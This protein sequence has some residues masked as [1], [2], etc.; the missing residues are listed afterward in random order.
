MWI[1]LCSI[2][3]HSIFQDLISYEVT[4]VEPRLRVNECVVGSGGLC[5]STE[6]NRRFES[7][8]KS[9]IGKRYVYNYKQICA[10]MITYRNYCSSF[11]GMT[12]IARSNTMRYF[13]EY[14]KPKFC[15][16]DP[17]EEEDDDFDIET[18]HCPVPGLQDCS[19]KGIYGGHLLLSVDDMK[20][21]F[22]PTFSEIT[23]LVQDQV[24]NAERTANKGV[25]V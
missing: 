22:D 4:A 1:P 13:D 6:L 15:P 24:S 9:K 25:T 23:S 16:P 11:D 20:G 10:S 14:L 2:S 3:K 21:I 8:V 17:N 19:L 5:G 12:N 7:L 18:Y